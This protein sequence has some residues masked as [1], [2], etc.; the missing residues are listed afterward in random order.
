MVYFDSVMV[1]GRN[2][3]EH[4]ENLWEVFERF[5]QAN[6][7]LKPRSVF[8]P[9]VRFCILEC[10]V[11]REGISADVRKVEVVRLFQRPIDLT[12]LRSFFAWHVTIDD[13]CQ[14]FQ[15]GQS[16]QVAFDHLK[17]L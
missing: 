4:L 13:L 2:F 1:I 3:T 9:V 14:V 16:E 17:H 15:W 5:C 10:V 7:K 12:S 11:S 8:W 6:L